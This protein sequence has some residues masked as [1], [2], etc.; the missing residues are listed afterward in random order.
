MRMYFP[1]ELDALIKY[2]GFVLE[3]KY[4]DYDQT[5]FGAKSEKQLLVC[6]MAAGGS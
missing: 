4:G 5:A 3:S 6:R 2:N 1:Q